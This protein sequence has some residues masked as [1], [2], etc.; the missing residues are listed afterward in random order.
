MASFFSVSVSV[1]GFRGSDGDAGDPAPKGDKGSKGEQG[2]ERGQQGMRGPSGNPPTLHLVT[3][4][5]LHVG[6]VT[7]VIHMMTSVLT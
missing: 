6:V 3:F 4:T 2:G 7:N 1:S 5:I